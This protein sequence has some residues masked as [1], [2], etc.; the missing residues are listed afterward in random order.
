MVVICVGVRLGMSWL[1]LRIVLI[2][3]NVLKFG[4]VNVLIG[5]EVLS[6]YVVMVIDWMLWYWEIVRVCNVWNKMF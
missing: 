1:I 2:L 5:L 6:V 4:V 3:M